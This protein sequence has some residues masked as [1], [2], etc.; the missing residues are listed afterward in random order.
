MSKK[1]CLETD[2]IRLIYKETSEAERAYLVPA[3]F[4]NPE[5]H[6]EFDALLDMKV[7]LDALSAEDLLGMADVP[8]PSDA[9][10]SNILAQAKWK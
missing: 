2:L 8:A 4:H 9:C 10:I 1:P 6:H 3:V 5:L 7:Q